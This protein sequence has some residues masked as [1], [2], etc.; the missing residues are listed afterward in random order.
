MEDDEVWQD[1]LGFAPAERG[2]LTRMLDDAAV[3]QCGLNAGVRRR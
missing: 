2:G 3:Q 1:A